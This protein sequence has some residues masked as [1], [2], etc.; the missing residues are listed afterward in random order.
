MLQGSSERHA[1]R[2]QCEGSPGSW[3]VSQDSGVV[4]LGNLTSSK[5]PQNSTHSMISAHVKT[6]Q[7]KHYA[8]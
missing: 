8:V 4:S 6:G 7:V 2:N 3:T 5:K 1:C